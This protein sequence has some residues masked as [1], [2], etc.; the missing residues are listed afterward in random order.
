MTVHACDDNNQLL[1]FSVEDSV[2]E[3]LHQSAARA[4][5]NHLI[6]LGIL[7]N[8]VQSSSQSLTKLLAQA[9]ALRFVP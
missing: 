9:E 2:R 1:N 8:F 3:S 6:E 5:V 7:S 4:T